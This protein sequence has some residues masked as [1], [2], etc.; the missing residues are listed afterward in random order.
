M[1]TGRTLESGELVREAD[2]ALYRLKRPERNPGT[3]Y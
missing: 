2:R 3:H 1:V